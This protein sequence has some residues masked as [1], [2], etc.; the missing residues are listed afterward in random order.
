MEPLSNKSAKSKASSHRKADAAGGHPASNRVTMTDIARLAGC[1]Q[2]TV[3][4]VLNNTP[5][6]HISAETR[7]RVMEAASKLK[8]HGPRRRRLRKA[9]A[10]PRYPIAILFDQIASSPEPVQSM[11]GAR[12]EAWKSGYIVGSYQTS[13]DRLVEP[14][15]IATVLDLGVVAIIYGTVMTRE[16]T[17][18]AEL[19]EAGVPVVLLNCFSRDRRFPTVIPGEVAGGRTATDALISAGHRRIAHIT[20]E[21]WMDAANDRLKGY[22]Q[23]LEAAD[24][25]F[26]DSLVLEGNWQTSA[27]YEKTRELMAMEDPPTAIFCSN[28]RMAVGCYEALKELGLRI[29]DD[30]SVVGYDDEEVSRH[31]SPPLTTLV[32]PHREMGRWAVDKALSS[33]GTTATRHHLVKLECPLVERESIKPPRSPAG[34]A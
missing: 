26:D 17:V 14:Q 16:V 2:S 1:S 8:Y 20:G 24:I 22:Q 19:Y 32:L 21:I 3:S 25:V 10:A 27:G 23:A 13:N 29:P 9:E 31:L 28:D 33:I 11:D 6:I 30:V 18:P 7:E 15:T 12:D 4:I 34:S 5:G